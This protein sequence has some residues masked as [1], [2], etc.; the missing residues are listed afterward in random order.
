ML[1][2]M[3]QVLKLSYS[4]YSYAIKMSFFWGGGGLNSQFSHGKEELVGN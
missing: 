1:T 3:I 4:I 2:R